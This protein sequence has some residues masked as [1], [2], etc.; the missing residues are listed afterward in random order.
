MTLL[1][2]EITQEAGAGL[3]YDWRAEPTGLYLHVPFCESKCIYCDF[4]SYAHMESKYAH[5]VDAICADIKRGVAGFLEGED[6]CA[7][8]EVA[9]VFFGGGTPS[10]L[11]PDQIGRILDAA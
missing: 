6:D 2:Q 7:G 3:T 11:Q 5:F 9:T 8:A 4:N 10:V 1:D